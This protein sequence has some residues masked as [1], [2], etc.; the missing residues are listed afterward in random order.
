M[1]FFSN[2]FKA[3]ELSAEEIKANG[4]ILLK[5][6]LRDLTLRLAYKRIALQVGENVGTVEELQQLSDYEVTSLPEDSIVTMSAIYRRCL[7]EGANHEVALKI[8]NS[9]R[10]LPIQWRDVSKFN[11][12]EEY[13]DKRLQVE[14]AVPSNSSTALKYYTQDFILNAIQETNHAFHEVFGC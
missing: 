6:K 10:V 3:K 4:L 2:I 9:T 8:V 11:T 7:G 13:I 1:G 14:L 5:K 12:I